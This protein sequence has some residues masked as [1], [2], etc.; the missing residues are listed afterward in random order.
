M[1][2]LRIADLSISRDQNLLARILEFD[3]KACKQCIPG[4]FSVQRSVSVLFCA[5]IL[6]TPFEWLF[7]FLSEIKGYCRLIQPFQSESIYTVPMPVPNSVPW[8][9]YWKMV[10][11]IRMCVNQSTIAS[12]YSKGSTIPCMNCNFVTLSPRISSNGICLQESKGVQ[13]NT[14]SSWLLG[15]KWFDLTRILFYSGK[16]ERVLE[17]QKRFCFA[18]C[19]IDLQLLLA[20]HSLLFK[21]SWKM[22]LL[23]PMWNRRPS[24]AVA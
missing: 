19:S 7:S 23:P 8:D 9:W 11:M 2:D 6:Y 12:W 20:S 1:V 16:S 24:T 4:N 17:N 21:K 5:Q 13:Y 22:C 15:I 18:C 10:L 3:L 14:V